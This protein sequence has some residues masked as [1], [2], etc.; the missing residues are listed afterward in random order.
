LKQRKITYDS[1]N[2]EPPCKRC[3]TGLRPAFIVTPAERP[4]TKLIS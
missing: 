3:R 1:H 4:D 2:G